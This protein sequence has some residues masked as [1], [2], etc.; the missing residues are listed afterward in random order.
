MHLKKSGDQASKRTA[1]GRVGGLQDKPL[2][3]APDGLPARRHSRVRAYTHNDV[4]EPFTF[5]S[6][7]QP[8]KRTHSP[9]TASC[10]SVGS[11]ECT[12]MMLG[13]PEKIR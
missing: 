2:R 1:T 11:A 8:V 5:P 10:S 7:T 6:T 9:S 4:Q 13:P 3:S 12:A